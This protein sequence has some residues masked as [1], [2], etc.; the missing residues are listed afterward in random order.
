VS[1]SGR[2]VIVSAIRTSVR[3]S[4]RHVGISA[5]PAYTVRGNNSSSLIFLVD[6]QQQHPAPGW[7]GTTTTTCTGS[8]FC[9]RTHFFFELRVRCVSGRGGERVFPLFLAN[10]R[11]AR[12][13][14]SRPNAASTSSGSLPF[15]FISY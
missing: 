5:A 13:C 8:V 10:P 15:T 3:Q 2:N 14:R 12:L 11:T 7:A 6:K 9:W 1:S 4:V